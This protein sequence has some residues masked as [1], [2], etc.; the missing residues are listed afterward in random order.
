[1]HDRGE[2]L[3]LGDKVVPVAE[4]LNEATERIGYPEGIACD[5]WRL[6]ELHDG[7]TTAALLAPVTPRGMGFKDGSEDGASISRRR[8]LRAG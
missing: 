1:M 4:L 2:L 3:L 5:R 7:M 6:G 8:S